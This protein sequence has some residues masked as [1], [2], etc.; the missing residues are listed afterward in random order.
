MIDINRGFLT[1]PFLVS[2]PDRP[3]MK[4]SPCSCIEKAPA[5]DGTL[6]KRIIHDL[7]AKCGPF[8]ESVNE[9][10][11]KDL[12]SPNYEYLS[13]AISHVKMCGPNSWQAI[14]DVRYTQEKN[15]S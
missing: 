7:S 14:L 11:N 15:H 4:A 1:G 8:N 6:R 3:L 12:Y 13:Q 10:I 2:D 9:S 5:P